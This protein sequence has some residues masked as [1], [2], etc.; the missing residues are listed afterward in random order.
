MS[1][2][3]L[4]PVVLP[5]GESSMP[6]GLLIE[7]AYLEQ[8]G[9]DRTL[10]PVYRSIEMVMREMEEKVGVLDSVRRLLPLQQR[11]V[12]IEADHKKD[13]VWGGCLQVRLPFITALTSRTR[14]MC[15][16]GEHAA[17]LSLLC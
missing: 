13:G 11:L 5:D 17:E 14:P 10:C 7:T 12:N 4:P 15:L 16:I 2:F 6:A 3:A 8:L 1:S 9:L